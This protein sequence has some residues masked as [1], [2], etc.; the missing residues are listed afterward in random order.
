MTF[1]GDV[2]LYDDGQSLDP[3]NP[4]I[5]RILELLRQ[6]TRVGIV[7][8]AGYTDAAKYYGRLH[9][10]L[11]AIADSDLDE[12][13]KGN[14]IVMGGESNF[15]FEYD[16]S[17]KERLRYHRRRDWIL[18]E[19]ND[20]TE[21]NIEALLDLAERALRDCVQGMGLQAELLRKERAVG[22]IPAE[23]RKL[24]REQLEETVLVCQR[25]LVSRVIA[26]QWRTWGL[27]VSR[28]CQMWASDCHSVR[29]MAAVM[30]L[31]T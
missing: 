14:L 3:S 13:T 20:W 17:V 18:E 25:I 2:T 22:I 28:R 9:G 26:G 8:A 12:A 24:T 5:P 31:L 27:T 4:A 21:E 29:S 1:D 19:M 6:G 11:D 30:S 10:L 23:G 15:L 7:T 16:G